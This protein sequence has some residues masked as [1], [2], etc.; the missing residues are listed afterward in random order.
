M[1]DEIKFLAKEVEGAVLNC[2]QDVEDF[3]LEF[4]GKKGKITTLF[5]VFKGVSNENKKELGQAINTLKKTAQQ[6]VDCLKGSFETVLS[7]Q[8]IDFTTLLWAWRSPSRI[9]NIG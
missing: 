2:E 4:L 6:K 8:K 5:D 1:L 9:S 3:R 7:P